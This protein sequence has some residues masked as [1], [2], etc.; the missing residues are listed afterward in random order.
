MKII[1]KKIIF[2]LLLLFIGCENRNPTNLGKIALSYQ[3]ESKKIIVATL[4]DSVGFNRVA[5]LCDTFGPRLSGSE[6]LEK[7]ILWIMQEME[8]DGIE[9]VRAEEVMVPKWVRGEESAKMLKPWPKNLAMLGLGGSIGTKSNGI[10]A[11]VIAVSSFEELA[12][13]SNEVKGKIV[14]FNV[15]FDTYSNTVKYRVR[16]AIEASKHGAV[17]SLVRSVGTFSMNTPHTGNSSYEDG[18]KKIPHAAITFEDAAIIGRILENGQDVEINLKMEAQ[19]YPDVLSHNLIGEIVGSE[20]PNQV[21]VI[22]GHIDSWDVGQ[23]AMDDAGG[24]VAAWNVLR[25]LKDLNI[26][27]KRTIRLVLWTNEENGLRGANS[28]RNKYLDKLKDHILAIESDAGVF[29]PSGFGFTGP[30]ES[31]NILQDIGTLLKP[32]QSGVI[33]KGGGGAD[34]GPIMKEGVPGMGLTV[35]SEKYFWYHHTAADTWDKLNIQEFNQC[36]ATIAVMSFVVADM[37]IRLPK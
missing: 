31:L 29:K 18:V 4:N 28:Y 21:I 23:G 35:E 16:G 7:A 20:F 30:D 3:Q 11:K 27:P 1:L 22:G 15:P 17:A 25:I 34:I 5:E 33:T 37:D 19:N 12:S 10:T 32:I 8:K 24:C 9:N 14:L 36:V 26:R 13:R 6:N 2:L